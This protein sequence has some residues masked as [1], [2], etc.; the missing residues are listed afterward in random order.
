MRS[1]I[2]SDTYK[3]SNLPLTDNEIPCTLHTELIQRIR[4]WNFLKDFHV[5]HREKEFQR[6]EHW[7]YPHKFFTVHPRRK[8][9]IGV[10]RG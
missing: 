9:S 4:T 1:L 8:Q 6:A 3:I 10:L 7:I 2:F 5:P